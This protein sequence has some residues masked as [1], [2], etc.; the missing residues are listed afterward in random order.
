MHILVTGGAGYIGSHMV[1]MLTRFGF[2]VKVFDNLSTGH[3]D[4]VDCKFLQLGDLWNEESL[5][6]LF[7]RNKFDAVMHFAA[8]TVV[9]DS[10]VNPMMYYENN[11]VNSKKLIDMAHFFEVNKFVFSSSAA[12]YGRPQPGNH[13]S[14]TYQPNPVNP[15]GRTKLMVEHLLHDYDRAVG[16]R[17]ASLRYFNAAGESPGLRERHDPETHLIPSAFNAATGSRLPLKIYGTTYD[18][19]DGTCIRDY[20]HVVDI[21]AAH[22][23][24]LDHI[25]ETD[26]SCVFNLGN[27]RGYSVLEVVRMI[28]KVTGLEVPIELRE[29]REGDPDCLVADARRIMETLGW[30][31][32]HSDLEQIIQSV[33][34]NRK[35]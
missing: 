21:C 4:A 29:P 16:F 3:S 19:F 33:W 17:S 1:A 8:S 24:A 15:Y 5:L 28:E 13:I 20:V 30:F 26:Q 22:L 27:A 11:F 9:A 34:S 18:T 6:K 7:K 23:L 32:R 10:I 14:E 2:K 25:I 12:V 31:P 35:C